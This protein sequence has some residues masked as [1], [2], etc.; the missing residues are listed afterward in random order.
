MVMIFFMT[1][2][3]LRGKVKKLPCKEATNPAA[4][5]CTYVAMLCTHVAV[6]Y[7]VLKIRILYINKGR[8]YFPFLALASL[9]GYPNSSL[10]QRLK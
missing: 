6:V 9:G 10:K 3:F 1:L 7:K 5:L 2:I 8:R 4:M